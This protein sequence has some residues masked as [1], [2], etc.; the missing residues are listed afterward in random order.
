MLIPWRNGDTPDS[1]AGGP[2]F[3]SRC[4]PPKKFGDH[5]PSLIPRL[6]VAKM[7]QGSPPPQKGPCGDGAGRMP[8]T[9]DDEK[10]V[11]H[12]KI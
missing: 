6:Q 10:K 4:R 1:Q 9:R 11:D 12:K 3:E 5:T 8:S 7:L 2:G